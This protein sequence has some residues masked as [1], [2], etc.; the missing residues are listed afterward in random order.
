MTKGM[1]FD[2]VLYKLTCSIFIE[3]PSFRVTT[4]LVPATSSKN[5][6]NKIKELQLPQS[7]R[8]FRKKQN[9]FQKG[10]GGRGAAM[11]IGGMG[12]LRAPRQR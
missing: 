6:L 2:D 9:P 5:A 7:F 11:G 4:V 1:T 3:L 8:P 10:V 12:G